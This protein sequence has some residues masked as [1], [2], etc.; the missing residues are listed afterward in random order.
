M[1]YLA[2]VSEFSHVVIVYTFGFV[3]GFICKWALTK[4]DTHI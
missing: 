1:I 4:R 3:L 2:E